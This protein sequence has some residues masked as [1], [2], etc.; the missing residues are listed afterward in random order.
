MP[1]LLMTPP[2]HVVFAALLAMSAVN[3]TAAE[4]SLSCESFAVKSD[5]SV[6]VVKVTALAT[7][8]G[9]ISLQPGM[10]FSSKV[11]L[12]GFAVYEL[13][14]RTCPGRQPSPH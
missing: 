11:K 1:I 10:R 6:T 3:A 9:K 2:I 7:P 12:M 8:Y 4:T 5:G 13:Y 14:E